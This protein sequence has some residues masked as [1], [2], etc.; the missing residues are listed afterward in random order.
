MEVVPGRP[1]QN[2]R[3]ILDGIRR[4][5]EAGAD[6]A[7]FPEMAVTGYLLGD[8][9]ENDAFLREQ[10]DLNQEIV[11][12]TK[13]RCAAVWGGVQPVFGPHPPVLGRIPAN[14]CRGEDG[15]TR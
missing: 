2:L 13:D 6:L 3:R 11:G 5:T 14:G 15:R 4:S 8:E 9:W 12:F 10:H 1:E 7:V